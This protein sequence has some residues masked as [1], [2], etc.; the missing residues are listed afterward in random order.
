MGIAYMY[1]IS[2]FSGFSFFLAVSRCNQKSF[3]GCGLNLVLMFCACC[4]TCPCRK[5]GF[6]LVFLFYLLM[7]IFSFSNFEMRFLFLNI[8]PF[9]PCCNLN[10]Y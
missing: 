5:F 6:I 7:Y 1:I 4:F 2:L 3:L 10:T 9:R 8:S